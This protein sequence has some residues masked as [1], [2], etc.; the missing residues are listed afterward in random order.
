VD[1]IFT[2]AGV[3][4]LAAGVYAIANMRGVV[5]AD[6]ERGTEISESKSA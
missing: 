5:L 1:T 6:T 3:M 4:I 2:G